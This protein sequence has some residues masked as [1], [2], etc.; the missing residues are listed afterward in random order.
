MPPYL[1]LYASL[2]DVIQASSM[3]E[4]VHTLTMALNGLGAMCMRRINHLP[5]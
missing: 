5:G 1:F 4:V 3:T 2:V